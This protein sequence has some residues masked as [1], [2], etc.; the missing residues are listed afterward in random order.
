M[1]TAGVFNL[2][3]LR[4]QLA[5]DPF[6]VLVN[7]QLVKKNVDCKRR[8]FFFVS[9]RFLFLF[10]GMVSSRQLR[11]A[12][13]ESSVGNQPIG[14]RESAEQRDFA[15]IACADCMTLFFFFSFN[16]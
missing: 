4:Y 9:L 16:I 6:Q 2:T 15:F 5:A 10:L 11:I 8:M 3:A 12:N 7:G 13:R 1:D 14:K